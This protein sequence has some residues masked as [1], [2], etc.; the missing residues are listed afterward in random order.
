M[1]L[2]QRRCHAAT[3]ISRTD[4]RRGGLVTPCSRATAE[5]SP[6][7]GFLTTGSI[8]QT[9]TSMAAFH[10][11]LRERGYIDGENIIVELRAADS[12]AEQLPALASDLVRLN[13]ALIV[14]QNSLAARAVQQATKTIPVVVPV[15]GDP[16]EDGLVASIAR[17]GGNIT[18]LTFI[19]PQLVPRGSRN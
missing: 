14:A 13:P 3:G 18:G 16:V 2:N 9:R 5:E 8:E 17:P 11:G 1:S 19:G 7:I 6:H 12:K 10:Q 4:R 15:M